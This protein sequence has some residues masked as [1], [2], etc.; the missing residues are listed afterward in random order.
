MFINFWYVACQSSELTF[1]SQKPLKATML[2]QQFA[3][4]RDTK[5][6]VQCVSNTCTHRSGA[7]AD[8]RIRGDCVEC[9][10]HGWTFDGEGSCVRL[11]SLGPKAKI[12]DRTRVDAY[13]VE[14][15]YGFVHVFLGD[16]PEAERPP[17]VS[18]PEYDDPD[19]RF[20]PLVLEWKIDYKRS[21]ENTMDPAHNEFTHPT[22][23]FLG[24]RE[25]YQVEDITL[26]DADWGT[27]FMN[28]MQSPPLPHEE[29]R[30]DSGRE[31]D[32][33]TYAGSGNH[34]PNVTWTY[35]HISDQAWFHGCAFHTPINEKLDRVY[36]IFGRNFMQ[37]PK[38]DKT[39]EDRGLY[40]AEQDRYVLEPM[41][42]MLTPRNN[43]HE[44]L[45]PADKAIG[46]YREFC[47][48][49]ENRGWRID[50]K[51]MREDEDRIAYA[52]P[53]PARRQAKGWV[54]PAIPLF[55]GKGTEAPVKAVAG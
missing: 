4:W 50:V 14:E 29:M 1:G 41:H 32:G 13:P 45:L 35:I 52:I 7:L 33:V 8:G 11:P 36:G 26:E 24:A 5:G 53:S 54:L 39:F 15:R 23:G 47:Q 17:I 6:K 43:V 28:A 27:G 2:G 31:V 10:Y 12:P 55:P 16:L 22:H 48:E 19:W 44:F 25:N 34:G 40:I 37:D 9:P 38:Y 46:R 20:I 49:W 51:K 21:V 18:M 30:K 3:L 42:P